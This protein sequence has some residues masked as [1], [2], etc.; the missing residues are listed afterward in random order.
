MFLHPDSL[1]QLSNP[2]ALLW[3]DQDTSPYFQAGQPLTGVAN[4][5]DGC[6]WSLDNHVVSRL[7]PEL[8]EELRQFKQVKFS[9]TKISVEENEMGE[10][11]SVSVTLQEVKHVEFFNGHRRVAD[12][13]SK[14]L[15]QWQMG[16]C[17]V[18]AEEI[19]EH[20]S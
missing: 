17:S 7:S 16:R 8:A 5:R 20:L 15:F 1:Y 13:L 11:G 3:K 12:P 6:F 4:I 14:L 19:Y 18:T 9:Y 2:G 10:E